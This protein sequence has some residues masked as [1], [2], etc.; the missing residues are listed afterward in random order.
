MSFTE[1]QAQQKKKGITVLRN[2]EN[3]RSQEMARRKQ[4]NA[5]YQATMPA[6]VKA[7][8]GKYIPAGRFKN[9]PAGNR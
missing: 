9:I 5:D 7:E 1:H 8:L 2:P 3:T 4:L 6:L